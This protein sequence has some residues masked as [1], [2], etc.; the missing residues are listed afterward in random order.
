MNLPSRK[1][2]DFRKICLYTL[3]SL[4]SI[5]LHKKNITYSS[6]RK[7]YHTYDFLKKKKKKKK[8]GERL[9]KTKEMLLFSFS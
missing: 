8:E 9:G 4:W 7:L 1:Q 6:F 2:Q 3:L 5:I